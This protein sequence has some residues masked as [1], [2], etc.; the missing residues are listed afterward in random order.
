M[1]TLF[2]FRLLT[3]QTQ[4]KVVVKSLSPKE[5]VRIYVP[6]PLDRNDGTFLVRYRMHETAHKGLKIE[7][8]HGSEHVAH[9]P[10]ILKGTCYYSPDPRHIWDTC[11][12]EGL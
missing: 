4:F 7:I 10:Y 12:S 11:F 5:L 6:K 8:L 3:G 2:L 9:S 1:A